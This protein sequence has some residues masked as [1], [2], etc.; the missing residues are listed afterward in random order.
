MGWPLDRMGTGERTPLTGEGLPDSE[1]TQAS[2]AV[3]PGP[4]IP[5]PA[6]TDPLLPSLLGSTWSCVGVQV[7]AHGN[8]QG[9]VW[10]PVTQLSIHMWAHPLRSTS[11][12]ISHPHAE[13]LVLMSPVVCLMAFRLLLLNTF[14]S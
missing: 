1:L 3:G 7:K 11:L 13:L 4:T 6:L 10:K 8:R 2:C 14:W 9:F 12:D 5:W